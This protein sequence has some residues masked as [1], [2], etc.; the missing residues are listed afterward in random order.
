MVR[1]CHVGFLSPFV[2]GVFSWVRFAYVVNPTVNISS[3]TLFVRSFTE[4]CG[5]K[6]WVDGFKYKF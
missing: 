3:G 4:C 6:W 5:P 2:F 1:V